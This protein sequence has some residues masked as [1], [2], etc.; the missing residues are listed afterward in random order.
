MKGVKP[1]LKPAKEELPELYH[2]YLEIRNRQLKVKT[3]MEEM[4]A[5]E[6]RGELIEKKL[7]EAQAAYL[8]VALRQRILNIP[9][10][11]SRKLMGLNDAA[12]V[13]RILR[14]MAHSLLT[15]IISQTQSPTPV[16]SMSLTRARA[17]ARPLNRKG[18]SRPRKQNRRPGSAKVRGAARSLPIFAA[19][20]F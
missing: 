5:A 18:R 19:R 17:L 10:S 16:G 4:Q 6:R 12:Q 20:A 7:I 15:E 14:E 2:E 13:S 11:W 1:R 8:L 9:H 3:Q